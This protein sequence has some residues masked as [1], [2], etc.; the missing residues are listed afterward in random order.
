MGMITQTEIS[1]AAAERLGVPVPIW[2]VRH[3]IDTRGINHMRRAGNTRLFDPA[4][5]DVV[6][7]E[8]VADRRS[9]TLQARAAAAVA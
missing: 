3:I 7:R 6:V 9:A 8:L 1:A 2:R 4:V 5:V